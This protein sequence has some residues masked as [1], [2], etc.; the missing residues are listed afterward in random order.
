MKIAINLSK[1]LYLLVLKLS[2]NYSTNLVL[3]GVGFVILGLD[4]RPDLKSDLL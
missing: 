2:T 4:C 3:G 1:I